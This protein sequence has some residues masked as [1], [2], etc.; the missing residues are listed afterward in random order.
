MIKRKLTALEHFYLARQGIKAPPTPDGVC[1]LSPHAN[2]L[3]DSLDPA[4]F[5]REL[6]IERCPPVTLSVP[7]AAALIKNALGQPLA[8][9]DTAA[10]TAALAD[11]QPANNTE[12]AI[13][14]AKS[15]DAINAAAGGKLWPT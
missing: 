12:T 11:M 8:G 13:K 1:L 3:L 10:L 2:G 5:A 14:A 6:A 9:G 4:Q 7:V 15:A